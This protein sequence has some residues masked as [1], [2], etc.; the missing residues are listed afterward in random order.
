MHIIHECKNKNSILMLKK[1]KKIQYYGQLDAV[2]AH[3]HTK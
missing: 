3:F 1:N 2:D